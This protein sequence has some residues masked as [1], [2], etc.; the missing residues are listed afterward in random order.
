MWGDSSGRS[1]SDLFAAFGVAR[2]EKRSGPSL[3]N[4]VDIVLES[5]FFEAEYVVVECVDIKLA[6][7]P[8]VSS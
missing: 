3:E 6:F 4:S 1:L 2:P 8:T 7:S 5:G